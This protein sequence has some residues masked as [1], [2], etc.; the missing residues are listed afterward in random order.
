MSVINNQTGQVQLVNGK[1]TIR[2]TLKN[3][4][5]NNPGSLRLTVAAPM[6]LDETTIISGKSSIAAIRWGRREH[7]LGCNTATSAT[8]THPDLVENTPV[9]VTT[10]W[11]TY[12]SAT[13]TV[14]KS[15]TEATSDKRVVG[16]VIT[17]LIRPTHLAGAVNSDRYRITLTYRHNGVTSSFQRYAFAT[18]GNGGMPYF[19]NNLTP[20]D[21]PSS[22]IPCGVNVGW[23][24]VTSSAIPDGTSIKIHIREYTRNTDG[25][26]EIDIGT[27]KTINVVVSGGQAIFNHTS[28]VVN[29]GV[30]MPHRRIVILAEVPIMGMYGIFAT[31]KND[32]ST[33]GG[34]GGILAG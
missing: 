17:T 10:K 13:P 3:P 5:P 11:E 16:G 20:H 14:I 28:A 34:G 4:A 22:G 15:V 33:G 25:G 32:Q 27:P 29:G 7:M 30:A 2:Y 31:V 6:G 24:F 26:P 9:K 23:R 8:Y 18:R 19:T 12:D 1:G 21:L